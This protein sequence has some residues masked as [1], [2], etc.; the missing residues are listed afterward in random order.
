MFQLRQPSNSITGNPSGAKSGTKLRIYFGFGKFS[1]INFSPSEQKSDELTAVNALGQFIF[2]LRAK[3]AALW[4][5]NPR[6]LARVR[7]LE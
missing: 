5:F 4:I 1:A 2:R 7:V 6:G 3:M